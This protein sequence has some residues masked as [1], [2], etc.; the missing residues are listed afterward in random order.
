MTY[1]HFICYYLNILLIDRVSNN[2]CI[3]HPIYYCL[4]SWRERE[5]GKKKLQWVLRLLSWL[6]S[7]YVMYECGLGDIQSLDSIVG[8]HVHTIYKSLQCYLDLGFKFCSLFTAMVAHWWWWWWW[9]G[10]VWW[11]MYLWLIDVP[12]YTYM[13]RL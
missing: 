8:T 13:D 9:V 10:W 4:L 3:G 11:V 7:L 5:G 2:S 1:L 6:L 12:L